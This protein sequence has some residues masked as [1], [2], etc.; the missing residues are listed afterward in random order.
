MRRLPR[1]IPIVLAAL[2]GGCATPTAEQPV[3][4]A[5]FEPVLV[6][7]RRIVMGVETVITTWAPSVEIAR[8]ATRQA[9]D[10]LARLEQAISDYRPRSEAMLATEFVEEDVPVSADFAA[11]LDVAAGWWRGSDGAID[12]T[13]GP[14]TA[15]WRDHRRR[16]AIPDRR[17]TAFAGATV[18]WNKLSVDLAGPT[19]TIRFRT[20]A[21]RLDFGAIGKGLAGD[22]ALATMREHGLP[23]TLV[24]LGGDVVAGGPPPGRDGW[25]ISVRTV[26][27][28]D[29]QVLDLA[30]GAVAT[31][32]D[33]EQ[34]VEVV[35]GDEVRRYGHILD[36][37][38]GEP[39]PIRREATVEV[40]G[41]VRPGADAD[42]LATLAVIAGADAAKEAAG[43]MGVSASIRTVEARF[44]GADPAVPEDW[45]V[46]VVP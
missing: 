9:F 22:L 11:A 29:E 32:G 44:P 46:R 1:L 10:R 36:P 15:L 37:R 45:I 25:R 19:P 8:D 34:F 31:S 2:L 24:D 33:V 16:G 27:W 6:V 23:R 5:S 12:P 30:T 7:D 13:I 41:G 43:R 38:T 39:V 3:D 28:D 42:A 17:S 4:R 18:G 14:L 21:M 35:D 26:A 40:R 20:A